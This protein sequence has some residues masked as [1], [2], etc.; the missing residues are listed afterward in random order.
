MSERYQGFSFRNTLP[1]LAIDKKL[2]VITT[3]SPQR[4]HIYGRGGPL[5]CAIATKLVIEGHDYMN[6]SRD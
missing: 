5:L 2:R 6:R 4:Y 1:F 3:Y